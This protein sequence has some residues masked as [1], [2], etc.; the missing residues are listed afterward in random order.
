MT[1]NPIQLQEYLTGLDF[2]VSKEDL[3]RRAQ[4]TGADT[5]ILETLRGLPVE[6]IASPVE[7]NE[8]LRD[9]S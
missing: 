1:V 2:P 4:E 9:V 8:A 7:I 5:E 3:L 6:Q